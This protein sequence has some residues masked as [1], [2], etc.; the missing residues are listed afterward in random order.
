MND[1][2]REARL[3]YRKQL[4]LQ[5]RRRIAATAREL[6]LVRGFRSTTIDAIAEEAGVAVSTVYS[7]FGNKRAILAEICEAW[8][9]EADVKP[10]S[11]QATDERDPVRKL[12]LAAR[13]TK[14]QWE[15]GAQVM[16][17]FEAA[18]REDTEFAIMLD[19]W[20]SQKN[21]VLRQLSASLADHLHEGLN[22]DRAGDILIA[23][24]LPDLYDAMVNGSGWTPEAYESWLSATLS[25]QL[26]A[27]AAS[28]AK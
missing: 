12:A 24:T 5:T 19:E 26:L 15:R 16:P 9:D 6:F 23:L 13:L 10:L 2:K 22:V 3:P 7:I 11:M 17:M 27:A 8:L 18:A 25:T 14:Q 20:K 28:A 1:V 21:S 4:A